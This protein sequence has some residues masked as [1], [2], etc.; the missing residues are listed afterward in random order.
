MAVLGAH[1]PSG[2]RPQGLNPVQAFPKCVLG[3]L[4]L[5]KDVS[6]RPVIFELKICGVG[7]GFPTVNRWSLVLPLRSHGT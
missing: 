4:S 1:L 2:E 5:L 3:L 6:L 7:V